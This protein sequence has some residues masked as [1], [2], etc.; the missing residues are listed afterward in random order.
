M[1]IDM[2]LL[3]KIEN[4]VY[5][6]FKES[7]DCKKQHRFDRGENNLI[8]ARSIETKMKSKAI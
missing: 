4:M 1:T 2:Q 3:R 7:T 6:D 5:R 8:E